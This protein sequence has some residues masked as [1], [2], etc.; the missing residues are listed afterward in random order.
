M[1]M[2]SY[3]TLT[4]AVNDL[5]KRG[6]TLDFNLEETVITCKEHDLSLKPEE[7]H[8]REVYRFEGES[9]PSDEE[10]VYAIES[11]DGK[12]GVLV[13]AFGTYSGSLSPEM[14]ARLERN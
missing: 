4:E 7:L 12:K 5:K 1:E 11:D 8:I 10:V 13:D 14:M 6:F 9:N 3:N 2:K